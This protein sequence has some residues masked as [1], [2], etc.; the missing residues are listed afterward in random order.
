M[1]LATESGRQSETT[2]HQ[3]R[4]RAFKPKAAQVRYLAAV[5]DALANGQ[6]VSDR[7]I[8]Q[9][10]KMSRQ[11]LYEWRQDPNFRRW[12]AEEISRMNE[13]D[14]QVVIRK[15]TQLAMRGSVKSAEFLLKA[16]HLA[17]KTAGGEAGDGMSGE[18]T[19]YKVEVLVEQTPEGLR[20]LSEPRVRLLI[21]RP[22]AISDED[23]QEF[24]G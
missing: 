6:P 7:A 17:W 2:R 15:H 24:H 12:L 8:C 21:P 1:P 19:N 10:L 14:W 20:R 16:R 23:N 4:D 22:P 11:T 18:T 9:S 13:N 5:E 3:S